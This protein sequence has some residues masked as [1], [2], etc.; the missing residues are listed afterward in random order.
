VDNFI[1]YI[2]GDLP[3]GEYIRPTLTTS[4][5]RSGEDVVFAQQLSEKMRSE[6][7][8]WLWEPF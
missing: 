5:A 7:S 8:L 4:A 2:T 6:T 1:T 3:F